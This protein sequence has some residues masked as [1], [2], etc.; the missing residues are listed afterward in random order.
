MTMTLWQPVKCPKCD[1]TLFEAIGVLSHA[2]V[3]IHCRCKRVIQI[4]EGFVAEVIGD[5][6][7][8]PETAR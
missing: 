2:R 1:K 4:K 3:K 6:A 7:P 5:Q 8:V